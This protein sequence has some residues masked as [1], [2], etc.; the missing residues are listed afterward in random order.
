M[1]VDG[2]VE[3]WILE[4]MKPAL[5]NQFQLSSNAGSYHHERAIPH[6]EVAAASALAYAKIVEVQLKLQSQ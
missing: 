6:R 5:K 4:Q 1:A 2:G 3:N